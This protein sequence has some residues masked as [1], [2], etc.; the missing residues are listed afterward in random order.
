[1]SFVCVLSM[2][3]VA[4]DTERHTAVEKNVKLGKTT[5]DI[6]PVT[7]NGYDLPSVNGVNGEVASYLFERQGV[8][9]SFTKSVTMDESSFAG[10]HWAVNDKAENT[11]NNVASLEEDFQGISLD[12]DQEQSSSMQEIASQAKNLWPEDD[13][14]DDRNGIFHGEPWDSNTL[15]PS[16]PRVTSEHAVSQPINMARSMNIRN[17]N[18][19]DQHGVL[20]PRS[21]DGV[22]MSVAEFVLASSPVVDIDAQISKMKARMNQPEKEEKELK[23]PISNQ[24]EHAF[25]DENAEEVRNT[26]KREQSDKSPQ[27]VQGV[28]PDEKPSH[29]FSRTPGSRQSSPAEL[30]AYVDTTQANQVTTTK[31][32]TPV[33]QRLTNPVDADPIMMDP[34][35]NSHFDNFSVNYAN[36]SQNDLFV[37][38]SSY[39]NGH[40]SVQVVT[41]SQ[42]SQ[43]QMSMAAQQQQQ[44]QQINMQ[45]AAAPYPGNSYFI[46]ASATPDPYGGGVP[47]ASMTN[48]GQ[49]Q[50][51]VPHPQYPATYNVPWGV[52]QTSNAGQ[53]VQQQP[54]LRTSSTG[55]PT[56]SEIMSQQNTL[57]LGNYQLLAAPG[58]SL[59]LGNAYYDQSGNVVVGTPQGLTPAQLNQSVRMIQPLMINDI[60]Q[61]SGRV[62]NTTNGLR[63]FAQPPGQQQMNAIGS[64][65]S[66]G[67]LPQNSAT[68]SMSGLQI[69]SGG[70]LGSVG[71][72]SGTLGTIGGNAGQDGL[73]SDLNR[74]QPIP[75]YGTSNSIGGLSMNS[76]QP[77]LGIPEL[78]TP[79]LSGGF[80][81]GSPIGSSIS[82]YL[83]SAAPGAGDRKYTNALNGLSNAGLYSGS[84]LSSSSFRSSRLKE[85]NRSRL[86]EDFR[87]NRFP[88]IQLR[89]L[90]NHIVEF[91]QDQHGSRFIQ[92]KLERASPSEKQMVFNEILPAAYSLMTDVFGNYVIQKFFEFGNRDQKQHLANCIQGHVLP[93]ALQM[94][95]CRVIQKALECIPCDQQKELVRELD[96]YVLKCVKDQNGN[97]VVQKCIE[98]VDPGYLHFIIIAFKGQVVALSTHPYG[99]RVIQRILEHCNPE[100]T[101]PILVELHDNI[102]RLVQDQYGNYVIQHVLEHGTYDDKSKI[103]MQLKGSIVMLSQHK[104]ASNVVEKC[105]SHASRPDRAILIEEVCNSTDGPQSGL[106]SMMKDQFANYVVQKMIDVAEAPQRKLLIL[107][108]RP[109]VATLKKYTYGKHILA[110]L[111]KYMIKPSLDYSPFGT[112][113]L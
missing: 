14:D 2:H 68:S 41:A 52:Y 85:S 104:F 61:A 93:L 69:G 30:Q 9:T 1:M 10:K 78:Q 90:A 67:Y 54:V 38:G 94:Y 62:A 20:S 92:Q 89:D 72:S 70:V 80:H 50:Q 74:R 75:M 18:G 37:G 95:G 19:V 51:V 59:N 34:L 17:Y 79:P 53:F 56:G 83:P 77:T 91:S 102:E 73:M 84:P 15:L 81:V 113:L 36:T 5:N 55:R 57:S 109:Y 28:L 48:P 35:D 60:S 23:I 6:S 16:M 107:K 13:N 46:T 64:Q 47:M 49:A 29:S 98:C 31:P 103:V 65:G 21:T 45:S 96:G 101:M 66:L 86:L 82:Q 76:Q 99:C 27:T 58:A 26:L 33:K 3:E 63:M 24:K 22:G 100:Q 105:I 25:E 7:T 71:G 12:N 97:H 43:Q 4:W 42:R 111:E 40:P 106:F 44:Q 112:T 88:N 32:T 39:F 87:N 108:I 110:K 11:N 8:A